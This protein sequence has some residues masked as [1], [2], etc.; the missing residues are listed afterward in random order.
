MEFVATFQLDKMT[1][2]SVRYSTIGSNNRPDFATQAAKFVR[3]KRDYSR[4]GQCQE[5]VLSKG[6]LARKFYDKWDP[7][8]LQSLTD[9]ELAELMEDMG[10]LKERYNH[11][12]READSFGDGGKGRE[13]R[14]GEVVEL[15]KMEP[16]KLVKKAA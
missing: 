6:T 2:F 15:S 3:S 16:K 8:H 7:K 1:V 14:F 4:C 5:A 10:A 11:V 13:I 9:A 12:Y